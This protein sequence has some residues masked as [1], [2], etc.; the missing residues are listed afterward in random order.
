MI[1][2]GL[3][4]LLVAGCQQ[5]PPNAM[6]TSAQPQTAD[7][8]K[9][10]G[11]N[12]AGE[13]C[14]FRADNVG[15]LDV[16]AKSAY[17]VWCGTWQQP[18]A[19]I[20]EMA[21]G[22]AA[23]ATL[24]GLAADSGWR[25][26]LDQFLA[27]EAPADTAILDN[28][29]GVILSCARRNGGWPHMALAVTLDGKT[30]LADAVPSALPAIETT[31]ASLTGHALPAAGARASNAAEILAKRGVQPFGSGDLD[32]YYGLMQ[33]GN[34]KN[35]VDDFAGAEDAF[36]DA[37]AVQQ[38]ILGVNNPGVAASLMHLA[39]QISNQERFAEAS[40]LFTRAAALAAQSNDPLQLAELD[41]YLAL[42]ASNQHDL[43][44]AKKYAE[45]SEKRY[46]GVVPAHLRL[47][48]ERGGS[49]EA[50]RIN[51]ADL[52]DEGP[53]QFLALDPVTENGIQGLV[54][55]WRFEASLA[56]EGKSYADAGKYTRQARAML[57]LGD[58]VS[59]PTLPRVVRIAALSDGG[60]GDAGGATRGLSESTQ[61]FDRF[62]PNE[63]PV[64]ITELLA[65]RQAHGAGDNETALKHFRAAAALLRE[66]HLGV[67]ERLVGPYLETLMDESEKHA[68]QARALHAEMFEAAQLVQSGLTAQYIAKA[69]A[70]LAAGDQRVGV[71]LR[72][73]QEA[74]IT[75]KTLFDERDEETQKPAALQ[76][77]KHLQEIDAAIVRA[78]AAHA[79]AEAA[80]QVAAPA[81]AQL[82]Q[83]GATAKATAD[84]LQPKEGLLDIELGGTA[85]YGFL[86]TR[87]GVHAFRIPLTRD[88]TGPLVDHLRQTAQVRIDAKGQPDI[89]V[90]DVA[91]A[92]D[93][94]QKLFG[95]AEPQ[96]KALDKVVLS[97]NGPLLS[98]PFEMLVSDAV[99]PV[100][101]GDY[102]SVPFLVKRFALTYVPA[103]QSFVRLR[104]SEA[105]SHASRSYIGFGD[106][107]APSKA[108]LAASFPPD[109]CRSDFAALSD[110]GD[111]PASRQ[112]VMTAGKELHAR[113]AD[114]VLGAGFTKANLQGMDL[115]QYRIL[116]FATHAF[117]PT[118][119][120]C[121]SEPTLLMSTAAGAA[122]ADAA[123]LD[124]GEILNLKLDADLVILSACNTA[125]PNGAGGESLSGLARSFFFAGSRGL[126]VTHWS[127]EDQ[128]SEFLITHALAGLAPGAARG[129]TAEALRQAKL[130]ILGGGLGSDKASLVF[131]HPF[132]WA[133]MVLIGDGARPGPATAE[134]PGASPRG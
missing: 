23:P 55:V 65:G 31:L 11:K 88:A 111:L 22:S 113:P 84:L 82:I 52:S 80:V 36:R 85:S 27:C 72:Q 91:A 37:L 38:K 42:H 71:A 78:Q 108:Q 10:V 9:A 34:Q 124:A 2:A 103:P 106:F 126:L 32:R 123:F 63:K 44:Q 19:H 116:H 4:V 107:R 66:R 69:S 81:Y 35:A 132:A 5:L 33:L 121:K 67:N 93:L 68:D 130:D 101:D 96:L 75:T 95:P 58:F 21:S 104:Q 98:L 114:M 41:Y 129:S 118:E 26:Y 92:H 13:D 70:R 97:L 90:Y 30:F 127:V 18:S 109:R 102:R 134:A 60:T 15:S 99:A 110:L 83:T 128:S 29:K 119:L 94:Y 86:V 28:V 43:A 56:Y 7:A 133:P 53:L 125:G 20:F 6:V 115:T 73:L 17:G 64:A 25:R 122:N 16:A 40:R 61:L 49:G 14:T 105:A 74:E 76:N 54:E 3:A 8:G 120:R 50:A 12:Q 51:K 77:A 48:A 87:D 24:A 79:D 112:E 39:L 59:P 47:A 46:A 62:T 45:Q 100:K 117:L 1:G 89:P 57:R 131:T